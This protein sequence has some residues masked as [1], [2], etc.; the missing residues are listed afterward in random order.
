MTAVLGKFYWTFHLDIPEMPFQPCPRSCRCCLE[1]S[2]ETKPRLQQKN[3][4]LIHLDPV[5]FEVGMLDVC[6]IHQLGQLVQMPG[7]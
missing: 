5:S 7:H 3:Q 4:D 1:C 2:Y 6:P